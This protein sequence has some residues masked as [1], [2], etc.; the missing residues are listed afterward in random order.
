MA[1]LRQLTGLLRRCLTL[2]EAERRSLLEESL[3]DSPEVF[4]TVHEI[5]DQAQEDPTFLPPGG[6]LAGPLG[7]RLAVLLE[8]QEGRE[9]ALRIGDRV[10]SVRLEEVLGA[11]GMG[12]VFRGFDE[13]LERAVAVKTLLSGNRLLAPARA[14]FRR[15]ARIDR[16]SVV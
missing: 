11:G 8:A 3:G 5:L 4:E 13:K 15:E 2:P 14:R 12:R 9:S 7:R 16:K 6:A 1:D 10:G